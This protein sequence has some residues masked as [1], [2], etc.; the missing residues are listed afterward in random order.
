MAK[1]EQENT[2]EKIK[3]LDDI[4]RMLLLVIT[5]MLSV[6]FGK[7]N[8]VFILA[9]LFFWMLGH[10]IG[11]FDGDSEI[12]LKFTAW[13]YT[14]FIVIVILIKSASGLSELSI[15]L[16]ISS[17]IISLLPTAL[18]IHWLTHTFDEERAHIIRR[19]LWWIVTSFVP[20]LFYVYYI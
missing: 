7:V 16:R 2:R 3:R 13:F 8:L 19:R 18:A 11:Q 9:P 15:T 4:F 20:L 17:F 5:I 14:S 1:D 6:G 10:A 12:L